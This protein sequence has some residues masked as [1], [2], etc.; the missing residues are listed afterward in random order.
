[1][2]QS[3]SKLMTPRSFAVD[4]ILMAAFFAYMYS[5]LSTHVPSDEHKW[6]VIWGL[7]PTCCMTALFWLGLQM[8]RVVF[9]FQREL[10]KAKRNGA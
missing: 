4:L 7:I 10:A 1:M 3:E 9:R 5:V 8:F 2:A 6:I